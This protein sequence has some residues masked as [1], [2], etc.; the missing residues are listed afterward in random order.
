MQTY[1]RMEKE[2]V[3]DSPTNEDYVPPCP[4]HHNEGRDVGWG[5]GFRA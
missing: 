3:G 2:G 4:T 5:L 1:W